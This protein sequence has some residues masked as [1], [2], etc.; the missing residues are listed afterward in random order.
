MLV[1][2]TICSS[3]FLAHAL[4]LGDSVKT[5]SPGSRFIIG[6]VDRIPASPDFKRPKYELLLVESLGIEKFDDLVRK[7][8]VVE[9]NTAVKPFFIEH[10]YRHNPEVASV[11]YLDP[12]IVVFG[13]LGPL[14]EKLRDHA[15]LLTPHSCTT[16][17]FPNVISLELVM[18][19]YGVYNLG[20]IATARSETTFSFLRWWQR[21][22]RDHC[23]F[24]RWGQFVDQLWCT[25]VPLYF[26]KV[27]VVTDPGYN[28]CYW[29]LFERRI[30]RTADGYLVNDT[31]PL[32]F[33]HFS[34]YDPRKPETLSNRNR[35]ISF[36]DYPEAKPL[37]DEYRRQ[38]MENGYESYCRL[39]WL[40]GKRAASGGGRGGQESLADAGKRAADT[41]LRHCPSGMKRVMR[42]LAHFV[43]RSCLTEE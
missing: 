5:H 36:V 12:D 35:G 13:G 20:F 30:S 11:I 27:L 31:F 9:L 1:I 21:R 10:I 42:R 40:L 15:L 19:G 33:Y 39:P 34:G 29:N 18:L 22:L 4:T 7:Y 41:I 25:L 32:V 16:R 3:N 14:V 28:V 6:L 38:L 37:T 23:Y 17:D 24:G 2:L 26:P 43:A 8:N